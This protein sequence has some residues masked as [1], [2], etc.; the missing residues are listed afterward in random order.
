MIAFGINAQDAARFE[1]QLRL[2][3]RLD[4][5]GFEIQF[6][7]SQG[8]VLHQP[9]HGTVLVQEK[10]DLRFIGG[11]DARAWFEHVTWFQLQPLT[12]LRILRMAADGTN[13][14]LAHFGGLR[15]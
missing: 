15:G 1:V 11:P 10:I 5:G 14:R 8:R 3:D 4:S 7:D 13:D 2:H 6:V 12:A 9:N